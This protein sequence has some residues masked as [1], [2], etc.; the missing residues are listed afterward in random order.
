[1]EYDPDEYP[2]L[3]RPILAGEADVVYG[4]RFLD[5][6]MPRAFGFWQALGN[7]WLTRFSNLCTH[8]DLT[9]METCYK[10][11]RKSILGRIQ[12]REDRFGFEPEF[13]AKV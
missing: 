1:M 10:M 5:S 9:D 8:V 11:F 12:L 2:K 3:L 13:T 4:S 7:Q 6:G